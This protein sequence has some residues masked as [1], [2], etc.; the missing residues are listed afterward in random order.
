MRS[1]LQCRPSITP[2]TATGLSSAKAFATTLDYRFPSPGMS[3]SNTLSNDAYHN[4]S[5][6]FVARKGKNHQWLWLYSPE[7]SLCPKISNTLAVAEVM[8]RK[9]LVTPDTASV[10]AS[11]KRIRVC[12]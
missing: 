2:A 5:R 8:L 4:S 3:N 9:S 6:D 7:D 12:N 11:Y 1:P 10:L